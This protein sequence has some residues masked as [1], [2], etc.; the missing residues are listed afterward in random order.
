LA[1][2]FSPLIA[3]VQVADGGDDGP[4]KHRRPWGLPPLTFRSRPPSR[5]RY[6]ARRETRGIIGAKTYLRCYRTPPEGSKTATGGAERTP[7]GPAVAT[8]PT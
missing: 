2:L 4:A 8:W 1:I 6:G 7:L 5:H 3:Q